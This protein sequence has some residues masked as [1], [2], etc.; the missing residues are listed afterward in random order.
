MFSRHLRLRHA[1]RHNVLELVA[2]AVSAACLVARRSRPHPAR[3]CLVQQPAVEQ[4]VHRTIGR[5][6]LNRAEDVIP[7]PG[8]R[9]QY[10]VEIGGSVARDQGERF[11]PWSMLHRERRRSR[12][13][14]SG[15]SSS[16]AWR[17]PHGS[18]PAPTRL[19]SGVAA[20]QCGRM[21][22]RAVAPE[23]LRPVT[24]PGDLASSEVGEGDAAAKL[25]A[26]VVACASIAP[27]SGSIAVATNGAE[28]EREVPS[29]HST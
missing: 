21:I 25:G 4:N 22:E 9:A 16:W 14:R 12:P 27:V 3:E 18:R 7:K 17:A 23:K 29:T 11:A 15:A 20:F 19:E 13:P 2:K 28:A 10:R 26:P 24:G 1:E 8:H 6:H 5:P